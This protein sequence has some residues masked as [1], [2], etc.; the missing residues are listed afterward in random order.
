MANAGSPS[1]CSRTWRLLNNVFHKNITW[2]TT[3]MLIKGISWSMRIHEINIIKI[4]CSYINQTNHANPQKR[5]AYTGHTSWWTEYHHMIHLCLLAEDQFAR[6]TM[7]LN[8]DY[9]VWQVQCPHLHII[10]QSQIFN[11]DYAPYKFQKTWFT[12]FYSRINLGWLCYLRFDHSKN[13]EGFPWLHVVLT[14]PPMPSQGGLQQLVPKNTHSALIP[15][16]CL[17]E[18]KSIKFLLFLYC[19]PQ[20]SEK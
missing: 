5:V 12:S 10:S 20:L 4:T 6:M 8:G 1:R 9:S 11:T 2:I 3:L 18:H 15:K 17:W 7:E 16:S 19:P 14:A 13:F